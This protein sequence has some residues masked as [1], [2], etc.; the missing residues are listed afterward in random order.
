MSSVKDRYDPILSCIFSIHN[1]ILLKKLT[2]IE[3]EYDVFFVATIQ[4][5]NE[6]TNQYW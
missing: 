5:M 2:S 3:F 1:L 6:S 4:P